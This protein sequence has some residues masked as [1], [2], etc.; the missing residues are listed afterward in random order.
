MPWCPKCGTEYRDGITK[1]HDCNGEPLVSTQP[2]E[3]PSPKTDWERYFSEGGADHAAF[4][5]TVFSDTEADLVESLLRAY[6]IPL[7]RKYRQGG[8]FLKV[9]TGGSNM[10]VDLFV[11]SSALQRAQEILN[12]PSERITQEMLESVPP[13][14][15]EEEPESD[16]DAQRV[17]KLTWKL[18]LGLLTALA[19]FALLARYAANF[20]K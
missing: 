17:R 5:Q 15:R 16:Y 20:I 10:G 2:P 3:N 19:A 12:A 4:L 18:F 9:A 6:E 11:P 8:V 1:C 13:E 14:F 7:L